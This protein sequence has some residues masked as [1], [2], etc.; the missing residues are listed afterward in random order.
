MKLRIAALALAVAFVAAPALG[1]LARACPPCADQGAGDPCS[2][3][4]AVSC[5][6]VAGS[7]APAKS[8]LDAPNVKGA[9]DH[10]VAAWITSSS[11]APSERYELAAPT[12][13]LRLSVVRRL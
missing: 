1:A 2:S 13:P 6:G 9:A 11:A 4:A 3:L 7:A 12:S 8:T 5:C 10:G